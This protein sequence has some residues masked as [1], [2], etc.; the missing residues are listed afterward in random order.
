M[1]SDAV[2]EVIGQRPDAEASAFLVRLTGPDG[3]RTFCSGT[4]DLDTGAPLHAGQHFR[5]GGVTK[6]FLA[7]AVLS[8]VAEGRIELDEP[9]ERRL[10]GLLPATVTVRSL[11]D[12]TSGLVDESDVRYNDTAWFLRHRFDTFTPDQLLARARSRPLTFPTGTRQQITRANYVALGMLVEQVTGRSYA[13]VIRDRVL[14]PVG[15]DHTYLPGDSPELP[16]PFVRGYDD[17]VDVT[18]HSPSLH[19][20]AGEMVSTVA[21]LDR[22]LRAL[23][24]GDLLSSDIV[25]EMYRVPDV[26]YAKGGRAFCGAGLDSVTL[27][28]DVTV[29]GMVGVVHGYLAG[30][31]VG[32]TPERRLVYLICPTR[33]GELRA[34]P[35]VARLLHSAFC[36]IPSS[37]NS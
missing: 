1:T 6:T 20:A 8:L 32:A 2:R 3:T 16:A 22:F 19:G 12:H 4:A 7:V 15:L 10:P 29:W 34:P 24:A 33:R 18:R 5:I 28:G 26:P 11:L 17:G 21:D 25:R 13:E 14:R 31:V 37:P 36:V 30:I 27:P 9:V 23:T 35:I